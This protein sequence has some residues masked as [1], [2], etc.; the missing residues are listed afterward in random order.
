[1]TTLDDLHA[2]VIDDLDS[3]EPRLVLADALQ[4]DG[5]PRGEFIAVQC[6]L[7]RLGASRTRLGRWTTLDNDWIAD[8]FEVG[9]PQRRGEL[10]AVARRLLE[11]HHQAWF[12]AV[13]PRHRIE[14]GFVEH[15]DA[16]IHPQRLFAL[17]PT[18]ES[19]AIAGDADETWF[20]EPAMLQLHQLRLVLDGNAPMHAAALHLIERLEEL[21]QLAY[22]RLSD[23]IDFVDAFP[24]T[25]CA[26]LEAVGLDSLGTRVPPEYVVGLVDRAP[27]LHHLDITGYLPLP[28]SQLGRLEILELD[29][30]QESIADIPRW[31]PGLRA[32]RLEEPYDSERFDSGALA[33]GQGLP[34]LRVLDLE[35]TPFTRYLRDL[36]GGTGLT[37]LTH[38]SLAGCSIDDATLVHLIESRIGSRLLHLRLGNNPLTARSLDALAELTSLHRLYLSFP[39]DAVAELRARLPNTEILT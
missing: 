34:E 2:A 26:T 33:L 21:R 24:A 4:A 19:I 30:T 37:S 8:A 6:E 29:H 11:R 3:D 12:G 5:D 9:D 28:W 25:A 36:V 15:V 27:H 17:A 14:R 10:R 18:I 31:V 1:M 16:V 39:S 35:G 7:A 22:V 23:A 32:L 38:L 13:F 20:A